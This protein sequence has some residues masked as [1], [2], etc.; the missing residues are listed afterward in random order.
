MVTVSSTTCRNPPDTVKLF[1]RAAL[2]DAQRARAEQRHQRRVPAQD[3]ER[4]RHC[5]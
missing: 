4:T 2:V 3:V 5:R 1:R